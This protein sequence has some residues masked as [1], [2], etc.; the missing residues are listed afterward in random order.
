MKDKGKCVV[1]KFHDKEKYAV[2][3]H[4][5]TYKECLERAAYARGLY[6]DVP[7]VEFG[8]YPEWE[9]EL[10]AKIEREGGES[11]YEQLSHHKNKEKWEK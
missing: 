9:Y 3:V 5:G 8:V 6:H 1:V 2:A 10:H 11:V 4:G 7:Y